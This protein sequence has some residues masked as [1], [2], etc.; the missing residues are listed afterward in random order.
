MIKEVM[1]KKCLEAGVTTKKECEEI[2]IAEQDK[3]DDIDFE[4]NLPAECSSAGV[5]DEEGCK[6]ILTRD[7]FPVPCQE[8]GIYKW[9]ECRL[10]MEQQFMP[11]ECIEAGATTQE[12]CDVIIRKTH[13]PPE[14][15]EAGANTEEE[16]DK[17]MEQKYLPK[18]C[19]NNG[20]TTMKE[21]DE[22]F[23]LKHMPKECVEANAETPQ[24][25]E[26][27]MRQMHLAPECKT[28]GI[29]D[30]AECHE[31]MFKKYRPQEIKCEGRTQAECE[32]ELK[33][34][35]LGLM[36]EDRKE[37]VKIKERILPHVGKKIQIKNDRLIK[38]ESQIDNI[39]LSTEEEA[40]LVDMMPLDTSQEFSINI[41][42]SSEKSLLKEDSNTIAQSVPVVIVIDS[43]Q[44]GLPDDMEKRFGTNPNNNDSDGDGYLDGE[45]VKEN[46]NPLGS[47]ELVRDLSPIEHAIL[48]QEVLEQ[49][50]TDGEVKENVMQ[51]NKVESVSS[52]EGGGLKISGIAVPNSVVSVYVYSS[53]AILATVQ[54]DESGNWNHIFEEQLK[55][56]DH[57]I[58]VTIN[59]SEGKIEAKS[60]PKSFFVTKAQAVEVKDFV[61]ERASGESIG[62]QIPAISFL[63]W[64]ILTIII[65]SISVV[66]LK[67]LV[68]KIK[69]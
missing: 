32:I 31:Y 62:S 7:S 49:P 26:Q 29:T 3:I 52:G 4:N 13:M 24:E 50:I 40:E 51:V 63:F 35:H 61:A 38:D 14:C 66:L 60:N 45:E 68:D 25:C 64:V 9:K 41:L 59:D 48:N 27:I 19:K 18:E 10:F 20:L 2:I 55:D 11:P 33:E 53:I 5:T 1:P 12:E 36:I 15:L 42:P 34:N 56:G 69:K 30:D 17:I 44:D 8:K 21:C 67:K 28:A 22:Y 54:T 6:K 23:M 58:Y 57:D 47:A 43:D 37:K 46:F 16:C 65:L 39:D